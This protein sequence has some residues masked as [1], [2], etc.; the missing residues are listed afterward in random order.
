VRRNPGIWV[1]S[2]GY[3]ALTQPTYGWGNEAERRMRVPVIIRR[4][5]VS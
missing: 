1:A 4:L 2:L 5:S 3:A